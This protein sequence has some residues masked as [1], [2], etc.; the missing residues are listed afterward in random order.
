MKTIFPFYS[1]ANTNVDGK[2][3]NLLAGLE[4][5]GQAAEEIQCGWRVFEAAGWRNSNGFLMAE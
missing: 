2:Q 5:I 4:V 1:A 3:F